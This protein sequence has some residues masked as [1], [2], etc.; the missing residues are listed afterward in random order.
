VSLDEF[1]PF[2]ERV[3]T[4]VPTGREHDH[5][6]EQEQSREVAVDDAVTELGVTD[7]ERGHEDDPAERGEPRERPGH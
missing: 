3:E 5:R 6:Q 4:V 2:D 7:P 1:R